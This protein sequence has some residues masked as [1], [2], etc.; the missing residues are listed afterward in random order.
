MSVQAV[1]MARSGVADYWALTKPGITGLVVVTTALGYYIAAGAFDW[2]TLA[3]TVVGTALVSAGSCAINMAIEHD[4]DALMSRTEDRPVAAGRVSYPAA[5]YYGALLSLLGIVT[6]LVGANPLASGLAIVSL[7]VYVLAYTPLKTVTTLNTFV[8]A[9]S[10]AI[11][12]MI[13]WAA[14]REDV[15][16]G[17][18]VLFAVM[19]LWQMPHFLAIGWMYREDYERAGFAMLPVVDPEGSATGRQAMAQT[20]ALVVASLMP[21]WIG[22]ASPVY[23][24]AAAILGAAFLAFGIAFMARRTRARARGLFLASIAYLPILLATLAL[25]KVL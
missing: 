20:M 24:F 9:V 19:F 16:M 23:Y 17:A 14:A 12:P 21:A 25:T 3:F 8:G 13:G 10:G 22:M 4:R 5:V 18:W 6:L 2:L 7:L 11:P 15:S 1:A